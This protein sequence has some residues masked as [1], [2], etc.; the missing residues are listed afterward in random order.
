MPTVTSRSAYCFEPPRFFLR[1]CSPLS[2]NATRGVTGLSTPTVLAYPGWRRAMR[3]GKRI[4]GFVVVGALSVLALPAQAAVAS[5]CGPGSNPVA[6]ENSKPGA[7]MS[8]W[9]SPNAWGDIKG[10]TTHE[11]VRPGDPLQFK[12]DSPAPYRI[13][14]YRLGWYGGNGARFMPSSP[15]TIFPAKSQGP[16]MS[17]STGL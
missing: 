5:P 10:F 12:V 11:S 9:Y 13:S 8:D 15:T 17:D 6:C 14:I 16:C 7:P 1:L 2:V 4:V 3:F